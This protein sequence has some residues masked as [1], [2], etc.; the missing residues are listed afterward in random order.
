MLVSTSQAYQSFWDIPIAFRPNEE[1]QWAQS[2]Q[3][4]Y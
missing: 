4:I 1:A 2:Q 3:L